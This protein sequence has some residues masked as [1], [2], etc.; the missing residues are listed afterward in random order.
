MTVQTNQ[1]FDFLYLDD[2]LFKIYFIDKCQLDHDAEEPTP[3]VKEEVRKE[4]VTGKM[5]KRR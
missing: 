1:W 3:K 4:M 2:K 5:V